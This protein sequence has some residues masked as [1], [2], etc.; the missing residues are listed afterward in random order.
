MGMSMGYHVL[1]LLLLLAVKAHSQ[2]Q[3]KTT[4]LRI[5]CG[6]ESSYDTF[7]D[8]SHWEAD[9]NYIESGMN[10]NVS[11]NSLTKL[12]QLN[13]LRVFTKG[14]RNCY[15]LPTPA[16]MRYFIKASF[17]YG[18]YDRRSKGPTFDLEFN[19]NK[20]AT[21]ETSSTTIQYQEVIH[22]SQGSNNVSVCLVRTEDKQ[23]P[24]ISTL[25]IWPLAEN[26]YYGM[27]RD[28]AWIKSYRYNYGADQ[29]KWII[30]YPDDPYNRVWEPYI[31]SGLTQVTS[32]AFSMEYTSVNFPPDDAITVAVEAQDLSDPIDLQ[33]TFP[34]TNNLTYIVFYFTEV[35]FLGENDTR[36]IDIYINNNFLMTLVPK[37]GNCSWAWATAQPI[38][39]LRI[40]LKANE[41]STLPPVISAVEVYT[42][43]G[44]GNTSLPNPKRKK[45]LALII[46][47][48]VGLPVGLLLILVSVYF[49]IWR[50]P[51]PVQGQFMIANLSRP[52]NGND[53]AQAKPQDESISMSTTIASTQGLLR[54]SQNPIVNDHHHQPTDTQENVGSSRVTLATSLPPKPNNQSLT[55]STGSSITGNENAPGFNQEE[56]DELLE[57]HTKRLRASQ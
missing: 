17:F 50:K 54:P 18:N 27:K 41:N 43:S 56:L 7:D 12:T 16:A 55:V 32:T 45:N 39:S 21:I 57:L 35:S 5:D 46:G 1:L 3:G 40:Q 29:N 15:N 47:L 20:W 44:D 22:T 13:T 24:F 6:A 4:L 31:P 49:I 28:L 26:M 19:G 2:S 9:E 10:K 42:A 30:G 52:Q 8:G 37:Y 23:F 38:D 34:T 14:S 36:Y 33:F 48:S 11:T 53:Q 51:N 25:E